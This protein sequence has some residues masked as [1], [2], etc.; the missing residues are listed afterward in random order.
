MRGLAVSDNTLMR[1][2]FPGKGICHERSL[3]CFYKES[4]DQLIG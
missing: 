4:L 2:V 3:N 1:E